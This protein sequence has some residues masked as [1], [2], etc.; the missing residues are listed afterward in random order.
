MNEI[1]IYENG[2]VIGSSE[3]GKPPPQDNSEVNI[4]GFP[5]QKGSLFRGLLDEVAL[6]SVALRKDDMKNL[7]KNGVRQAMLDVAPLNKLA[8]S[9]GD[10]KYQ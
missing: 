10:I 5:G 2:E 1:R 4:G 7:M 9:W 8:T 6:F 3:R